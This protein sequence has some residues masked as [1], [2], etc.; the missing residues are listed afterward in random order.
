MEA[1]VASDLG[2]A[3][4]QRHRVNAFP[5]T[6]P[7]VLSADPHHLALTHTHTDTATADAAIF[8]IY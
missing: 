8:S 5:T 7:V 1:E 2:R 3:G 4:A 6:S